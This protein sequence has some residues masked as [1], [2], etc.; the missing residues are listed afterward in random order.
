MNIDET[1]QREVIEA[2]DGDA[3]TTETVTLIR[4]RDD[5]VR[6]RL[7]ARELARRA[8]LGPMEQTRFATAVSELGRNAIEHA[9]GG[10]CALRDLSD[11]LRVRLEAAIVDDGPGIPDV[12]MA[13]RDGYSSVGGLGAGLPGVKR[14]VDVFDISTSP[15]GTVV[16]VQIARPRRV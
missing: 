14:I 3:E 2:W 15:S 6:A 7:D 10:A 9:G 12:D 16:S 13:M 5:L 11:Q 8:G 4:G 1:R